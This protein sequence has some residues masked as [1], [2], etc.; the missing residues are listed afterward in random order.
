MQYIF[1]N[2]SC[3]FLQAPS[4]IAIESMCIDF[5][6][7]EHTLLYQTKPT[8]TQSLQTPTIFEQHI[9][10]GLASILSQ[11]YEVHSKNKYNSHRH[12]VQSI[13]INKRRRDKWNKESA[14]IKDV[15][16][17]NTKSSAS[18][19][20]KN[21]QHRRR[22]A[23]NKDATNRIQ[24]TTMRTNKEPRLNFPIETIQHHGHPKA[25][26]SF[27]KWIDALSNMHTCTT[28]M[29]SY[30]GI[31]T[32]ISINGHICSRCHRENDGH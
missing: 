17:N 24:E 2:C 7:M 26:H 27:C 9:P 20:Q 12:K 25:T 29:E 23:E 15:D 28:C 6:P 13:E 5:H 11:E 3:L 10:T 4:H 14:K 18:K 16:P 31:T 30:L 21:E 8:F 32:H 22:Y 1:T 19:V